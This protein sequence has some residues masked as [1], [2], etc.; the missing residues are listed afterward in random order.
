[1]HPRRLLQRGL[2]GALALWSG[3][4]ASALAQ[5]SFTPEYE[6][7][8]PGLDHAH[9]RVAPVPWS[10]YVV[11]MDRTK[12]EFKLAAHLAR[13]RIQGLATVSEQAQAARVPG[14]VPLAAINGGYFK[15]DSSPYEGDPGDLL[16]VDG[17]LLST[18]AN[19]SFWMDGDGQMH[20]A[21]IRS[22]LQITWPDGSH[23]PLQLNE[24][25]ATNTAVLFTPTFGPNLPPAS[26]TALILERV[27]SKPWLPLRPSRQYSVRVQ[28]STPAGALP[29]TPDL[30]ILVV[31]SAL[32]PPPAAFQPGALLEISTALSA[33]LGRARGGVGGGPTLLT[34]GLPNDWLLKPHTQ[35]AA[36]QRAPRSALGFNDHYFFLVV[37]DGRQ[38]SSAGMDY[39]ELLDLVRQLGC[40]D[41]MSLDGG[42]STTLW[43][44]GKVVNSP[45]GIRQRPTAD[46][47]IILRRDH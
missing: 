41:A 40:T 18:P 4:A 8:V 14:L 2:S 32:K 10:I 23:T 22:K 34:G 9:I 45:S 44:D 43:V 13:E 20:I 11:R 37:V 28:A 21:V 35:S 47:L 6:S 30:G 1:M 5:F 27:G 38:R 15:M 24:P 39:L 16:I 3:L 31:G 7:V 25:P 29:L 36:P 46:A 19:T 33:D 42:G 12:P 26:G 17:E